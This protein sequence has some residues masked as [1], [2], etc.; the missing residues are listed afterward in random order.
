MQGDTTLGQ[1]KR[2][3]MKRSAIKRVT[4]EL[5]SG[6]KIVLAPMYPSL[7]AQFVMPDCSGR[8][9]RVLDIGV[10]D[11]LGIL[12]RIQTERADSTVNVGIKT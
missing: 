8:I 4:I 6:A 2:A 7:P 5:S 1:R 9:G 12:G 11:L 3:T 10:D